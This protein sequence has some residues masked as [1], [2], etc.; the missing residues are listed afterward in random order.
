MKIFDKL[1]KSKK[2]FNVQGAVMSLML[3][4]VGF[5]IVLTILGDQIDDV[6]TAGNTV[7]STSAPLASLFAG[8]GVLVLILMAVV[9]IGLMVAA[10]K[11]FKA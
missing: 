4:I 1:Q 8:D 10:F 9:F 3:V 6:Q 5:I 7:N 2:G 11:S